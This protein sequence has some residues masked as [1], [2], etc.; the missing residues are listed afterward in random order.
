[1][2]VCCLSFACSFVCSSFD[3]CWC[4]LRVVCYVCAVVSYVLVVD[5]LV[6]CCRFCCCRSLGVVR[7][8][9]LFVVCCC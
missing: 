6:E 4:M 2:V 5:V 9:L 7:C 3:V 8:A 1:M